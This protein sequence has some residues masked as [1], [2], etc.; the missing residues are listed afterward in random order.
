MPRFRD[1]VIHAYAATSRYVERQFA[2]AWKGIGDPIFAE[3]PVPDHPAE[4]IV[5]TGDFAAAAAKKAQ[6]TG[7]FFIKAMIRERVLAKLGPDE[8]IGRVACFGFSAGCGMLEYIAQNESHLVDF[9][10]AVDGLYQG[11]KYLKLAQRAYDNENV[12]LVDIYTAIEEKKDTSTTGWAHWLRNKLDTGDSSASEL[13]SPVSY[14]AKKMEEYGQEPS[15]LLNTNGAAPS[16]PESDSK[17][18]YYPLQK[19]LKYYADEWPIR[20]SFNHGS[21]TLAGFKGGDAAAHIWAADWAQPEAIRSALIPRWTIEC[22]RA[23]P[24][25]E[26]VT[27]PSGR[28][29]AQVPAQLIRSS[30]YK[31]AKIKRDPSHSIVVSRPALGQDEQAEVCRAYGN[32]VPGLVSDAE[33]EAARNLAFREKALIVGGVSL[34][35]LGAYYWQKS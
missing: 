19:G 3:L 28:A 5:L 22:D 6:A 1:V 27:K 17:G 18:S 2:D 33:I 9:M 24:E 12:Q 10:C 26:D 32:F 30:V 35:A 31:T 21:L 16:P 15:S 14:Q 25:L 20:E 7:D 13:S 11:Q 34:I 23:A 29:F 4:R 8:R